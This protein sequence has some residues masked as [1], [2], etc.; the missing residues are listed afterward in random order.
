MKQAAKPQVDNQRILLARSPMQGSTPAEMRRMSKKA[1]ITEAPQPPSFSVAEDPK[2]AQQ[3][4]EAPMAPRLEPSGVGPL[5]PPMEGL[6]AGPLTP[7]G[8]GSSTLTL[9]GLALSSLA[10]A[11]TQESE[12]LQK[13]SILAPPATQTLGPLAPGPQDENFNTPQLSEEQ[14]EKERKRAEAKAK[15]EA[16][17]AKK[18]AEAARKAE[19]LRARAEAEAKAKAEAEAKRVEQERLA[20][21]EAKRNEEV[22]KPPSNGAGAQPGPS[23]KVMGGGQLPP[24]FV[25]ENGE[26]KYVGP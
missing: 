7:Q 20:Q 8:L 22:A 12:K 18:A 23:S 10:P 21:E 17:K 25:F 11:F 24:G 15:R 14:A 9:E 5:V 3:A 4:K 2:P 13:F 16:A 26:L 1:F 6:G 19:E